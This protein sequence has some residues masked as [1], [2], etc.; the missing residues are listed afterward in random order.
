MTGRKRYSE[1]QI[2]KV[3][4][5]IDAGASIASVSRA[6][7]ISDQT[8]YKWREKYAGMSKSDLT[9]LRALQDENR[10]LRHLVAELSL[11]NAAYK[12]IQKGKW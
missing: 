8:I 12:E 2:V 1:E 3:L 7:G 9:Q 5:E 4:G 11:D 6:G 10:R